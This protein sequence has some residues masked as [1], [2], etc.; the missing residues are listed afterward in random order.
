MSGALGANRPLLLERWRPEGLGVVHGRPACRKGC[1][2]GHG[3]VGGP[4][5]DHTQ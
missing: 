2:C 5:E 4:G 3:A 1:G